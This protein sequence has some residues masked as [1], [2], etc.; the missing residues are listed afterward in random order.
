[1]AIEYV[2]RKTQL[3]TIAGAHLAHV[4]PGQPAEMDE[5]IERI[6]EH[7]TTVSKPDVLSVLEDFYVTI[8]KMLLEGRN[9]NTPLASFRASITGRFE[10]INDT[11]EANRHRVVPRVIPGNR[12]RGALAKAEVLKLETL[13]V[14]PNPNEYI[15]VNSGI[16]DSTLTSGG[17]GELLGYR[18]VFDPA[19]PLQGIFFR[20][21]DNTETRVQV[22]GRNMPKD[23]L[24][25]VPALPAGTYTVLVRAVLNDTPEVRE[26]VLKPQLTVA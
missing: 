15:D 13:D 18:L 7:N 25:T 1:M 23:L 8:E 24:F 14:K 3:T 6:A 19:D 11:F 4:S 5:I 12:L 22:V 26:G 21:Q 20:A 10:G 16:H 2:I 9:V 17:M